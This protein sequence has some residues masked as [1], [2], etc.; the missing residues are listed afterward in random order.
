M[1]DVTIYGWAG[2]AGVLL[3][4]AAYG[5][6]Q[7]GFMRGSS[8][9]YTVTNMIAAA[10]ILFSLLENWN[11]FSAAIQFFWIVISIVGIGRRI[12]LGSRLHFTAEEKAFLTTHLPTL[13]PLEAHHVTRL[14]EWRDCASGDMLARQGEEV[15]A[16]IYL[17]DGGATVDVDG[18]R[19]AKLGP[20]ALV[21]EM[22]LMHGGPATADVAVTEKSRVFVMPRD[23]LLAR[24]NT[25]PDIA[26][27]IG[28]ALQLEAQRKLR[29][30]NNQNYGAAP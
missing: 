30:M 9:S 14:G 28:H 29:L 23:R 15:G 7:L 1:G 21:G 20:E 13:P 2:V 4:L 6:L 17:A 11:L 25:K 12:W 16:L 8:L 19:V 22:T 27:A 3:Y 24:I 18:R 5:A 26:L 10:S